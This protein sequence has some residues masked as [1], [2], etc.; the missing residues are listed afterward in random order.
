VEPDPLH[1]SME[2]FVDFWVAVYMLLL[3]LICKDRLSSEISDLHGDVR[4]QVVMSCD[5]VGC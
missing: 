5:V 1:L 4:L 2:P 3:S